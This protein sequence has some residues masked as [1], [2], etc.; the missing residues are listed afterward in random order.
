V[1][2][3]R[4]GQAVERGTICQEALGRPW[5]AEDRSVD[6][7]VAKLRRKLEGRDC[8]RSLRGR[9]YLFVGFEAA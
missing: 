8:I 4:E 2:V 3:A 1:L 5:H 6:V 7:L 9:G